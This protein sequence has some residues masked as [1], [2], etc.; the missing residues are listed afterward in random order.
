MQSCIVPLTSS[1]RLSF[2]QPVLEKV[3]VPLFG[4][5]QTPVYIHNGLGV[6]LLQT[7]NVGFFF[8]PASLLLQANNWPWAC[9]RPCEVNN[10]KKPNWT[11]SSEIVL[12]IGICLFCAAQWELKTFK[13]R[14]PASSDR[15]LWCVFIETTD[16]T[17]LNNSRLADN[18]SID[19]RHLHYYGRH[20]TENQ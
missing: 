6:F 3:G 19:I 13:F 15:L 1:I 17:I 4:H 20:T 12:S 8:G 18:G 7:R 11:A 10:T 14:N 9:Q 2:L 16:Q 5:I